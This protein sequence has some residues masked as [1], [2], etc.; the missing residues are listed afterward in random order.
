[1]YTRFSIYFLTL[2]LGLSAQAL[3]SDGHEDHGDTAV[4]EEAF[5]PSNFIIHHIADA[6]DIHLWGEGHSAVHIPLPIVVYSKEHGLDVFMSSAFEGHGEVRTAKRGEATYELSHGHISLVSE[7]SHFHDHADHGGHTDHADHAGH[8]DHADHAYHGP[9]VYDLSI[10]KSIF[11]M[12]LMLGLLVVLFGRMARSYRTRSGQAPTGLTNALEPLVL[13]LRDEIAVPNIGAKKADKFLPFLLSV[14][15]FIFFANLLGLIP[16]L[17]GFNVTGTLGITM[18]LAALV[19]LITTLNGNKHYW[20]HLFWPPGVPLFVMPII[21]PIEI[22]GMFLKPIVL[23]I[24]LTANISAGHIII[25]SFVSLILIFGK[26]GEALA[27]GYG[28]GV[29]STAFMIFMYCLELLVAFLQAFVFTL[30]AAIYF[31]EATHEAHH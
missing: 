2:T 27:A 20:G 8:A 5:N 31:G 28:I 10:T 11:G 26:G 7:G 1:M 13:F 6:H 14:F 9:V 30:L 23:M 22:V 29:F 12:L 25:L 16:F 3:A 15:F 18:V 24:R 4:H 19:F 17:G 21:I